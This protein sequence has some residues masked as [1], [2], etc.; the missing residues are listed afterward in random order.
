MFFGVI[1]SALV[2]PESDDADVGT[3]QELFSKDF[4]YQARPILFKS[5]ERNFIHGTSKGTC[6]S[7]LVILLQINNVSD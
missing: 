1:I 7:G 5:S 4:L 6:L 3:L 2:L